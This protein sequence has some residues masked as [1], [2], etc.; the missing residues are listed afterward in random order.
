M[1][2][3]ATVSLPAERRA[4]ARLRI[5]GTHPVRLGRTDGVLI[6]ISE[7]GARV[8]HVAAVRRGETVRLAIEWQGERFI[9]QAEVL[10]SRVVS[11][12]NGAGTIYD[13]RLRFV[14]MPEG[15]KE[16]L[17]RTLAGFE[18]RDLRRW[19]AN[20]RGWE[21]QPEPIRHPALVTKTF[22]RFHLRGI[23][24]EK[25]MTHDPAQPEDGFVLPADIDENEITSL[26][27]T[28]EKLDAEGREVV[29]RIAGQVVAEAA[30]TEKRHDAMRNAGR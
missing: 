11:M 23:W 30:E 15:A 13:S 16:V 8:R 7:R 21:P 4:N 12:G 3:T 18:A 29:R 25:K 24:W 5:G 19:V 26:C 27:R 10:A 6:D 2:A 14:S 1:S 17:E 9:A 22:V 28:Y 20:L